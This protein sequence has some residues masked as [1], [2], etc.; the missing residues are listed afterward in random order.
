LRSFR[1]KRGGEEAMSR[2]IAIL[3]SIFFLFIIGSCAHQEQPVPNTSVPDKSVSN[4]GSSSDNE[5][6]IMEVKR[7]TT[8]LWKP[9]NALYKNPSIYARFAIRINRDGKIL[10]R[11]MVKSSGNKV[12]DKSVSK[13]LGQIKKFPP[14]PPTL[15]GGEDSIVVDLSFRLPPRKK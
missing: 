8:D 6:W 10:Q 2:R 12:Y 5:K 7:T 1:R 13:A 15:L 14:P 9:P 3:S 4:A 11:K